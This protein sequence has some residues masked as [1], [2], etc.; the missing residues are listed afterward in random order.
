MFFS[1]LGS[2]PENILKENMVRWPS[3]TFSLMSQTDD[4]L[5]TDILGKDMAERESNAA[6]M[7]GCDPRLA[8]RLDESDEARRQEFPLHYAVT[9]S[10][11]TKV[12]KLLAKYK[13]EYGAESHEF[14]KLINAPDSVL[15]KT[16][17][18]YTAFDHNY[19]KARKLPVVS[20]VPQRLAIAKLLL[21][22]G[23]DVNNSLGT[24]C[25]LATAARAGEIEIVELLLQ[26]GAQVNMDTSFMLSDLLDMVKKD[27]SIEKPVYE[28]RLWD[29][30]PVDEAIKMMQFEILELLIKYGAKITQKHLDNAVYYSSPRRTVEILLDQ[31]LDV[32]YRLQKCPEQYTT[33][34]ETAIFKNAFELAKLLIDR[35][36]KV[37]APY[38]EV[39]LEDI[40]SQ[41]F[42]SHRRFVVNVSRSEER[43]SIS[44]ENELDQFLLLP[45]EKEYLIN[46]YQKAYV[47]NNEKT[48]F[49]SIELQRS[50]CR[51]KQEYLENKL[52]TAKLINNKWVDQLTGSA[53]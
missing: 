19:P 31:G 22:N 28:M 6:F 15:D 17:L 23:A 39:N 44:I 13:G 8:R 20:T 21:E 18:D 5:I 12:E 10:D 46:L 16:P 33:P 25:P 32:N 1:V 26:N 35:G 3:S 14:L 7:M 50:G 48:L 30:S 24:I 40:T 38:G 51:A 36:A 43:D 29:N 47:Q 41:L 45:G 52:N 37:T 2:S 49:S 53:N 9:K 27:L 42:E 4:S 34:L 11:V